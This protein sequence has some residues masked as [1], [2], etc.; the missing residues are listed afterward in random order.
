MNRNGPIAVTFSFLT[1]ST[2]MLT[3]LLILYL[4]L[5]LIA[6]LPRWSYSQNWGYYPSSGV[7]IVLAVVVGL[8]IT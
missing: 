7:M 4:S 1:K 3:A 5:L 8:A 2:D 6:A